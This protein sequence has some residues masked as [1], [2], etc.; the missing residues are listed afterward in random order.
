MVT[1]SKK[2]ERTHIDTQ[3]QTHTDGRTQTNAQTHARM[4]TSVRFVRNLYTGPQNGVE[5]AYMQIYNMY[6]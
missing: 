1:V 3:T 5:V 2:P 6:M 4:V